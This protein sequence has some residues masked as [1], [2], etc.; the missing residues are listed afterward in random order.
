MMRHDSEHALIPT[1]ANIRKL[2]GPQFLHVVTTKG[3]GYKLAEDD[4]VTYHGPGKF[5]PGEGIKSIVPIPRD[6]LR[7]FIRVAAVCRPKPATPRNAGQ[8]FCRAL[9]TEKPAHGGLCGVHHCR[10]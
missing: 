6:W 2:S 7:A 9:E 1:L 8:H 5:D 3:Q 4:P 10:R